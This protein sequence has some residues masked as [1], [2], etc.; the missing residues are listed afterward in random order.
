MSFLF[1]PSKL[2]P[3]PKLSLSPCV[4]LRLAIGSANEVQNHPH[5]M[6]VPHPSQGRTQVTV[7]QVKLSDWLTG[8]TDSSG[9]WLNSISNSLAPKSVSGPKQLEVKIPILNFMS[10]SS[11]NDLL[12]MHDK[13]VLS[14]SQVCLQFTYYNSKFT[15][16]SQQD[17]VPLATVQGLNSELEGVPLEVESPLRDHKNLCQRALQSDNDRGNWRSVPAIGSED[18]ARTREGQ[19]PPT[20]TAPR[21]AQTDVPSSHESHFLLWQLQSALLGL[22]IWRPSV[23]VPCKSF[24][25]GQA[26]E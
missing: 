15:D 16:P 20:E 19:N 21:S 12:V 18:G 1:T 17:G 13:G 11:G 3:K 25:N 6:A 2:C 26:C 24:H 8:Q 5:S 4:S 14:S 23:L 7:Y 10:K 22:E 9:S